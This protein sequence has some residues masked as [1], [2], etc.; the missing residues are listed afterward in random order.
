M[1]RRDCAYCIDLDE[2]GALCDHP[3]NLYGGEPIDAVCNGCKSYERRMSTPEMLDRIHVLESRLKESESYRSAYADMMMQLKDE[4]AKLR[5][6]CNGMMRFL[7]DGDFC[8]SCGHQEE[9]DEQIYEDECLM[10]SD[11]SERMRELGIGVTDE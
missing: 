11:F 1:I 2:Q 10:R 8:D 5:E 4:N 7:C 6:L 9:C 3:C